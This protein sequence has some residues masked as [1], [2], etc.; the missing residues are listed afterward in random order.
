MGLNLRYAAVSLLALSCSS[1]ALAGEEPLYEAAP[2]WVV[3]VDLAE[4]DRDPSNDRIIADTQIRI[5]E[6]RHWEY[7]DQ[8]YRVSS[9]SDLTE[10]GTLQAQWLP[11]KGDLIVHEISIL[12]DGRRIDLVA[13][14]E[15]L[16]VLRREQMLEQHIIDGE[17]TATLSVPGLSVGDELRMAYSVTTSDQALGKEVQS[18]SYLWRKPSTEADFARVLISWPEDLDVHYQAGPNYELAPAEKRSGHNWLEVSL[19]LPEADDLPGDAPLRYRQPTILRASTF[20]GWGEVSSVMA[21]YFATE[22]ALDGLDD[23]KAKVEKIRGDHSTDL[24]RAVAALELVQEDI[25]YLLNGLDGGNY[26]PQDVATTWDKKYGD[27]KAKTLILLA[28]LDELGI[29]AEPVLASVNAGN[30]VPA[31]LPLPGAFDHVLVRATID[32]NL[33]YLDGTSLGAN[34]ALVG[35]VPPFEY[36]LPL[37]AEGADLEPIVQVL[38]RAAEMI[39][40]MDVDASAGGDLPVLATLEMKFIGA[41]AAQLNASADKLTEDSKRQFAR[42]SSSDGQ[43]ID[44]DIFAGEDDSEA[45]M[46]MTMIIDSMFDYDGKRAEF[47]PAFATSEI[48]F[49]PDRSRRDWRGIPVA[50]GAANVSTFNMRAIL[51]A[52]VGDLELR[53]SP[54]LDE[55]VAGRRYQREIRIEDGML[56]MTE[57]VLSLGG[58]IAPD[59]IAA[60]RRKAASFARNEVKLIAPEGTPRRWRFAQGE[61]RSTLAALEEAYAKVI[62]FDPEEA[63]PYLHRAGFRYQTYDF[64]GAL[65]DMDKVVEIDGTAEYYAQRA[66]V[67]MQLRDM[68]AAIADLEEAYQLEPTP[69]RAMNLVDALIET[70]EVDWARDLL[71]AEDGDQEVRQSLEIA[72]AHLDAQTGK[73]AE[74]LARFDA[75]NADDPN[76]ADIANE[77]CWFMGTRQVEIRD[78]IDVCIRAVEMNSSADVLDSRALVYYR[79]GMFDEALKDLNAAL[80]LSPEQTGSLL[81]RGVILREQGKR[82]GQADIDAALARDP[83]LIS[84]YRLFGF[85]F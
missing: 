61:D 71:E 19:P 30:A 27:C 73:G 20:D 59:Q 63:R 3:P 26:I 43:L 52:G 6:G 51:P 9:L 55:Q 38:P 42:N 29:E 67:H 64:A 37:R 49:S 47:T 46:V 1:V 35:N 25:R 11:D 24:E 82:E 56:T 18:L 83:M 76:S 50:V 65:L 32:G 5:E 21:P 15:R 14:G 44:V 36:A 2:D 39:L 81:L 12:R 70:G 85:E 84:T 31:S 69:W 66:T 80:A 60:E 10:V 74:G 58:E 34:M 40:T 8:I 79:N 28:L 53:G 48:E 7:T 72:L 57:H 45:T 62:A 13:Q 54:T 23:L 22:G 16:E 78:A 4:I 17:L 33:Y 68:D 77:Q 41:A 75:L